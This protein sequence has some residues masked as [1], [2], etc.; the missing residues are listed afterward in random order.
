MEDGSDGGFYHAR[1]AIDG[2]TRLFAMRKVGRF[3]LFLVVGLADVDYLAEWRTVASH[4]AVASGLF[5]I[6]SIVGGL[7][8]YA[9]SATDAKAELQSRLAVSVY[10][11]SSEG[12]VII[13]AGRS[14]VDVNRS[15]TKL[16]GFSV[17]E[18]RGRKIDSWFS[19]RRE[20]GPI[21]GAARSLRATGNWAGELWLDAKGRRAVPRA[22]QRQRRQKVA[23]D[24]W[25]CSPTPPNRSG[26][27][28]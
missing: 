22:R 7:L 17:E 19:A 26:P 9:R 27:R 5:L 23:T 8:I 24:M 13:N 2:V 28:K 12:M 20:V 15:F 16:T 4:L 3:P 25:R 11:N 10:E 18:A 14:I 1:S 6:A 21:A